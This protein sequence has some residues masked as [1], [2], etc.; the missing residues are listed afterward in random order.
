MKG[1][2]CFFETD[3]RYKL[4]VNSYVRIDGVFAV[5]A[6]LLVMVVYYIIGKIYANNSFNLGSQVNVLL[7]VVC[8]IYILIRKQTMESIGFG[9]RNI[10][11]SIKLGIIAA[12]II[13]LVNLI[14]GIVGGRQLNSISKLG[15]K[16]LYYFIIIALV[17]EI[18]FRG[19]IQTR[20]YGICKKPIIGILITAF[21]F[22]SIHIPFQMGKS[23]MDFL[24]YLLNNFAT[25]IF[26]F[27]WHVIFNF[28]YVKYNSI[29]APLIFHTIMNWSNYLFIG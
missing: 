11:K 22:M 16:F 14:P 29:A 7:A 17:E 18:V 13:F 6:Y 19:F 24:T 1:V 23:H 21:M 15:S 3:E 4:T 27:G 2:K 28:M 20:I 9:K 10:I 8:I 5:I 26:T 12:F 25:L